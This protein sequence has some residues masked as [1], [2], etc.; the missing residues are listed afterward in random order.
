MAIEASLRTTEPDAV[1]FT[2]TLTMTAKEWRQLQEALEA[3]RVANQ[4]NRIIARLLDRANIAFRAE[5]EE[6]E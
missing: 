5:D 2:L 4:L 1:K 6:V 3:D